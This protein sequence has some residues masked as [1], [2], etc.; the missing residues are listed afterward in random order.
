M[1]KQI[2]Y[3]MRGDKFFVQVV[4][5]DKVVFEGDIDKIIGEYLYNKG[6]V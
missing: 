4:E 6:W 5:D 1:D 3:L 2:Q